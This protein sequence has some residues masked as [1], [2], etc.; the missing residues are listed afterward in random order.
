MLRE[1]ALLVVL[2]ATVLAATALGKGVRAQDRVVVASKNFTESVVLAELMAQMLE[3]HTDLEVVRKLELGG[4]PVCFNAL[5]SGDVDIY[6]DY[7]G[8]CW[9]TVMNREDRISDPF[10]AFL[11]VES[12]LRDVHDIEQLP[13]FGLNNTY[14]LALDTALAERWGVETIS[15]LE[16]YVDEIDAAFSIEFNDRADGYPGLSEF[17][18][19]EFGDVKAMEHGLAYKALAEGD[20]D[21]I[22]AYATDGK[23]LEY[24]VRL[25][26]DDRGFF[27][28]YN[29]T[30]IV[31]GGLLE[32]HPQVRTV[33]ERLAW[34]VPDEVALELNHSVESGSMNAAQAARR[35]LVEREL[36]GGELET[37]AAAEREA[38]LPFFF[39]RWRETLGL[40]LEH[41][42]LSGV[43]VLCAALLAIPLGLFVVR[44]GVAERIALDATGIVQ[45]IPSL[46][47]LVLMIPLLG[48][49]FWAALAALFLYALLP[50]LR[51][52]VT[53]VRDV[54]PE[55]VDAARGIGLTPRQVLMKVEFPLALRSIMAGLRTSAV[56]SIGV[57]TLAAFIGQ[58]GL[59]EPIVRGLY[60]NDL[61]LILSGAIPA[62]VLALFVDFV[63][64]RVEHI[65]VPRGLRNT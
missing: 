63:L 44:R 20:I 59:G 15:D 53:G 36:V 50:I 18:G 49:S 40:A 5:L 3:E 45:T 26:E 52:T 13:P 28:P 43:A 22:D 47:L 30:P 35:F 23:L 4:T 24:D 65:V 9:A 58:G 57:A 54:D 8:T 2:A 7:T 34:T 60:L 25:L 31:R 41:I 51:N 38:F 42:I 14:V 39:G 12:Y 17:Y 56:I 62:A 6:A 64:G 10:R 61:R 32:D 16:P 37:L 11:E 19:F 55:L 1:L 21:L 46:A 27:P 48:I 33:L 29:A